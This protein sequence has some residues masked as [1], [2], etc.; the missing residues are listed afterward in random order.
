[1]SEFRIDIEKLA[2]GGSGIGRINGKVCFVPFSCPGDELLVA[3]TS[4]KRSYLT[5][6]IVEIIT[7]SSD[8]AT[9]TCPLFGSCGGCSWQHIAYHRQL[10]AKRRILAETLWRGA[11]I[12][13][14]L[15]AEVLP[16]PGQYGYR[17]RVQF[18]VFY[19]GNKLQIGFF[20]QGSH[21]VEDAPGGCPVALPV[22][23]QAIQRLR[24]VL[25]HFNEPQSIPQINIDCGDQGAVAIVS[26]IGKDPDGAAF[27][28]ESHFTSLVP[29]T[30]LYIQ[31]G[32]KSTLRKVCGDDF[33]V[34]AMP[35]GT[36]GAP[37]V[38]LAF[39][40]GGFSQVNS[41][42]NRAILEHLRRLACFDGSERVLDL[43]CGNG[44]LSLP[45]ARDVAAITGIEEFEGSIA[46]AIDNC[47]RNGIDNADY[48]V[49]DAAGGVRRLADNGQHYD[50]VILDPPRTGA[51]DALHEICRLGPEKIVYV[52]CDPNTLARD[53]GLLSAQGYN[54][55]A[56]IPVDMFPQTYH[57]ESITLLLRG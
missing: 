21:Y 32:R 19:A 29:L 33:L 28:L 5:A 16:A 3:L 14:E 7:P 54:V 42:Q 18:K 38:Q 9:P 24:E 27:F 55:R 8:R 49:A 36:A 4:E 51:A 39:R 44:N 26:Y 57:L 12:A 31:T 34:Y 43:Y 23:N 15:I 10:E 6:R 22:I 52:S 45:L 50:V 48:I 35:A 20:R 37:P 41:S 17:S 1:M 53:C 25:S 13:E 11:R 46:A 40:P 30:G 56:S 2:F 47:R